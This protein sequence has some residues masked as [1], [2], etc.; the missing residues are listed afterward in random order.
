MK[1]KKTN[2]YILSS[3]VTNYRG[4]KIPEAEGEIRYKNEKSKIQ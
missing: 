4:F 2:A 1:K 3:D